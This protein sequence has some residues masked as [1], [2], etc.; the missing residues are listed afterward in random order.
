LG[1]R[2]ENVGRLTALVSKAAAQRAGAPDLSEVLAQLR[3]PWAGAAAPAVTVVRVE[4][5]P[6]DAPVQV[7][8]FGVLDERLASLNTEGDGR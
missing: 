8:V 6:A 5:L 7:D 3:A 2:P 1:G 4:G